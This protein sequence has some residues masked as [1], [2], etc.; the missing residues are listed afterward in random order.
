MKNEH[1]FAVRIGS[2]EVGQ[3]FSLYPF[4][5]LDQTVVEKGEIII[6][7]ELF[8]VRISPGI[9]LPNR[10][11]TAFHESECDKIVY[12]NPPSIPLFTQN[13]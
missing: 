10:V 5:V 2:L 8:G 12:T 11:A 7:S 1:L 3:K 6:D 13:T 9:S 4:G